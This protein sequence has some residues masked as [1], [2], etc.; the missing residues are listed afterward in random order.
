M[1]LPSK[2][3][4]QPK[5]RLIVRLG[6]FLA[7]HHILF[8]VLC[9]SAGIIALL[10]L[11]SLAKSTYLSENALIPGSA[12][13]LFSNEDV[14]EANK[15]IRGIEAVAGESRGGSVMPKFIAQQ[16][17]D[18]GAEVCYHEFLPHSKHFHPLKFF[19]SMA[20]D[21]PVEPNGTYTNYG[22][23]TIGIIRAPRGDGKEAIVLVTP[24][25]SQRAES[26]EV[27]SLALGF[28]VFSLLSR[29]AW[30]SKDIVWLSAD[31]QFGEYTAV[32]AWLNQYHNP[33][34]LGHPTMLDSKLFDAIHE[35]DGITEKAEFMDFKRA[36]T[37]AAALIFK[38]GETRNHGDRDSLT[39]YAEASNGQ[40]PNLD[41]LN[42]VH[43][44]AVHRQGFRVNIETI[45]S[46][47]SSA[48]LRVIAEVIQ[49]LG[50]LLRKINP[51]WKLDIKAPDYVEGT[52]N[53]ASSMY[54]Q[55][56]GVPT[57]SHGA[58]RD[59]Q[60]DAVSLEF[61]P[62]FDLR[63]ENAKSS[64]IVRGGRLIEG[65]VRSV[66]NLL[67]KFH[68]SFFLYFLAAPS[69][70]V[71]VGVYMIPFALLLA[72]L[73]IVAAALADSKTKGKSLDGS[74]TKVSADKMQAEGGSW[75][76]LQA[77]R[78]LLVIQFWAVIV[79]LLPYY[80]S[81]IPD[82]TPI[83]SAVIWVVLSIILLIILY[84]M[85]GSPY[86]TG[87][88]WKLLK[89]TMI[90]SISIGLGLMS[91]INFATAQLGALIVIPMCLFSRPLK[92]RVGKN[93]FPRA[94]LLA[95]NIFIA[96]VGFPPAALLIVKGVSKG[97]WTL[98]IGE[99]WASMEFLWEWSSATYLYLF[100]VHLPCWLL[101]IHV[102][103]HPCR[104][105]GS[106]VKLE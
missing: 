12:N 45:N 25:N 46:L 99:F 22:T 33:M 87:V 9:C 28:S 47:L 66:N 81:Q 80:I 94:V 23:N 21:L 37:M 44:L 20:K 42:V 98:D 5:P 34:F 8:S 105:A 91:I 11:P 90:T 32:S 102:L 92:A 65:V 51:D 17:K 57:G 40:M 54:N 75:K 79:S 106:K 72:P 62:T 101:C 3:D 2:E 36:G 67:E 55:A 70:F 82:G 74:K 6:V 38:V 60:V 76:W 15:F 77:A 103:L 104:Q 53:L 88:E 83:Q 69:K 29:A 59:Y 58:F 13:P 96:V 24:Y 93:S 97:S 18:L 56:L 7:S 19:T 1:E 14:M 95:V 63:N 73:P 16:I 52:A 41:L 86:S 71:S 4:T 49:T 35:P 50:S 78:V 26:N 43:Y 68:Q 85:F 84:T 100:L 39:M 30:L 61:S 48:W 64:F 89:A 27:L 31:S 10:F